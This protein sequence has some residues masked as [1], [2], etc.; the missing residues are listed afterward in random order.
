ME[1]VKSQHGTWNVLDMEC[2]ASLQRGCGC[3]IPE[4]TQDWAGQSPGQP[5]LLGDSLAHGR[6][7][8]LLGF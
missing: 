6:G 5:D 2:F 3:P 7:L 4:G 8:E 1:D